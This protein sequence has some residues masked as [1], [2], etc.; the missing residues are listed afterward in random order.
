MWWR[1]IL[2]VVLNVVSGLFVKPPPGPTASTLKDFSVPRS[3]EG[4]RIIDFAGTI[5]ISDPHVAWYGDFDSNAIRQKGG[6][7]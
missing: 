3:D 6:K 4:A 2:G 1:L 5:W 7:K